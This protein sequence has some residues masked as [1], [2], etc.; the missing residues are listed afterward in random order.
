MVFRGV[1][2]AGH[3]LMARAFADGIEPRGIG[4]MYAH[5]FGGGFFEHIAGAGIVSAFLDIQLG[6]AFR[7][8]PQAGINGVKAVN[9]SLVGHGVL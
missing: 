3:A 8:L 2:K 1:D 7:V 6:D 5:V 9:Q 4:K